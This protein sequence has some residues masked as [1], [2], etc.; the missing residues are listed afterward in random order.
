MPAQRDALAKSMLAKVEVAALQEAALLL[1]K[2][3]HPLTVGGVLESL[4]VC[5]MDLTLRQRLQEVSFLTCFSSV[6]HWARLGEEM[7][8]GEAGG[9]RCGHDRGHHP[10][11]LYLED[12][13]LSQS[14]SFPTFGTRWPRSSVLASSA[15]LFRSMLSKIPPISFP[16]IQW[17]AD[18]LFQHT[19]RFKPSGWR[20]LVIGLEQDG[21]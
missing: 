6:R 10:H 14:R 3:A 21:N 17:S 2:S 1:C 16:P 12:P 7:G 9:D 13:Y 19:L 4:V 8:V 15:A 5:L 11:Y 18:C 20:L